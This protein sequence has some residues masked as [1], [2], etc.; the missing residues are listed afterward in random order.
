[1]EKKIKK[2]HIF[3]NLTGEAGGSFYSICAEYKGK[4]ELKTL[5]VHDIEF[6]DDPIKEVIRDCIN[7]DYPIELDYFAKKNWDDYIDKCKNLFNK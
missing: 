4:K 5:F 2:I 3:Y 6:G 1:M 7:H